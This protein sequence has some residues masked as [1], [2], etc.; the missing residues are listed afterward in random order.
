MIAVADVNVLELLD[1][2][3]QVA[4]LS[5]RESRAQALRVGRNWPISSVSYMRPVRSILILSPLL[6]VPS[7][8]R[9]VDDDASIFI[10]VTVEDECAKLVPPPLPGGGGMRSHDYA[11]DFV[12]TFQPVLPLAC[13]SLILGKSRTYWRLPLA[14][15]FPHARGG[16]I[17][18]VEDGDPW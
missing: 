7:K 4:D 16:H 15:R 1:V 2:R 3:Y 18:F 13:M 12:D 9:R 14:R 5:G 11:E 6:I 17:D 10:E 8:I